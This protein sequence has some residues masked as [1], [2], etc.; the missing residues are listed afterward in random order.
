MIDHHGI[1][2][3][4][5]IRTGGK[6]SFFPDRSRQTRKYKAGSICVRNAY[7]VSSVFQ[8]EDENDVCFFSCFI[9]WIRGTSMFVLSVVRS[10]ILDR[11]CLNKFW[12]IVS[13]SSGIRINRQEKKT[14]DNQNKCVHW[15]T[16]YPV[17][18]DAIISQR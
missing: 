12:S 13:S 2:T 7:T 1:N 9:Q 4:D 18:Y 15:Q 16:F 6:T 8:I 17:H 5:D 10:I 14:D 3:S 11:R